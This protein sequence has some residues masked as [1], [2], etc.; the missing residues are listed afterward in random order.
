[1]TSIIGEFCPVRQ[2]E[3]GVQPVQGL[4]NGRGNYDHVKVA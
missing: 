4:V 1:M 3:R 2:T